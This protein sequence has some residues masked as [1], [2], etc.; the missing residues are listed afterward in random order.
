MKKGVTYYRSNLSTTIKYL[1]Q[2][3]FFETHLREIRKT[4][5][6]YLFDAIHQYG[7]DR[8]MRRCEK[9]DGDIR[10]ILM[11]FGQK[12]EHFMIGGEV[13][14]VTGSDVTLIFKVC[15]GDKKIP[16]KKKDSRNTL[17]VRWTFVDAPKGVLTK[18]YLL[19]KKK[20]VG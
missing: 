3:N 2:L 20:F 8:M 14:H 11:C 13:I 4:P 17:W 5:T 10:K 7:D 6:W 1:R 19:R 18:T 16:F 9:S 12:K 15:G